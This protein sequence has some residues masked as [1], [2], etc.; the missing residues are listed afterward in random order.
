MGALLRPRFSRLTPGQC[1]C[2]LWAC[3]S[4]GGFAPGKSPAKAQAHVPAG[5]HWPVLTGRWPLVPGLAAA[6]PLQVRRAAHRKPGRQQLLD[7]RPRAVPAWQPLRCA[8]W[9][10]PAALPSRWP[11]HPT[12]RAKGTCAL[13]AAARHSTRVGASDTPPTPQPPPPPARGGSP[14]V[15]V[16][17]DTR[18]RP[19]RCRQRRCR[20]LAA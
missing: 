14:Q 4:C 7:L 10:V 6:L 19:R 2:L 3:R 17:C 13:L 9:V 11:Q 16:C 18:V 15:M 20:S 12:G 8:S 1:T 5:H